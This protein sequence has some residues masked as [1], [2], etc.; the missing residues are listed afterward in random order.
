MRSLA[1]FLLV[2]DRNIAL[3]SER[4]FTCFTPKTPRS[5][6]NTAITNTDSSNRYS[7]FSTHVKNVSN[8]KV[9]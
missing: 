2:V 9:K 4:C 5:S 6:T 7:V 8:G 3:K 1:V